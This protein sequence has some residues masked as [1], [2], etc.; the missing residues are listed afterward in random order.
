[1]AITNCLTYLVPIALAVLIMVHYPEPELPA[2]ILAM[3][4]T[5]SYFSF[6]STANGDHLR[7]FF[8]DLKGSGPATRNLFLL[9]GFPVSSSD[10]NEVIPGL[11]E[12][13]GRLI[14]P[15]QLGYGLS[16]KPWPH[17][18]TIFEQADIMEALLKSSGVGNAHFLCHDTGLTVCLEMLARFN[19]RNADKDTRDSGVVIQSF[20]FN[21]GGMFS[22]LTTP[23]LMQRLVLLPVLG[24]AVTA[25]APRFVTEKSLMEAFGP[26][27]KPSRQSLNSA[28]ALMYR[29]RGAIVLS[30]V[31]AYIHERAVHE[32]RWIGAMISTS[33]PVH[34]IYNPADPVNKEETF[35]HFK[36]TV[37]HATTSRMPE[38]IG[39]WGMLEDPETFLAR[40][41]QFFSTVSK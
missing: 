19:A 4:R 2:D 3:R 8:R 39:H 9:H 17:N 28:I 24:A 35:Q 18:Y 1:M 20:A 16:D 33:I 27:T 37:P 11:Q 30:S 22:A 36:K 15:E 13:F 26:R 40:Y 21:N 6:K 14:V 41:W 38:H 29:Q 25:V 31:I 32:D 5:G 23:T 10:W 7:I 12:E 34:Y